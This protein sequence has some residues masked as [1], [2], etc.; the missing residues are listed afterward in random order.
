ME[1]PNYQTRFCQ[2]TCRIPRSP[3]EGSGE[4][5]R[6]YKI[7]AK[8]GKE[9]KNGR[10]RARGRAELIWKKTR[11]LSPPSRTYDPRSTADRTNDRRKK[12][13]KRPVSSGVRLSLDRAPIR[14]RIQKSLL[15]TQL[16]DTPVVGV[17]TIFASAKTEMREI[18][19]NAIIKI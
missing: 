12:P 15:V 16:L 8:R 18:I 4:R 13:P 1:R 19:R 5:N 9:T 2:N 6:G 7:D 14:R 17:A 10:T 3:I 11:P